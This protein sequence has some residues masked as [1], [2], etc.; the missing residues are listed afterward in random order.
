MLF[1]LNNFFPEI[2]AEWLHFFQ[3]AR[4]HPAG[5]KENQKENGTGI[6]V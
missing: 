2:L 4:L 5:H 3:R 6:T 1:E